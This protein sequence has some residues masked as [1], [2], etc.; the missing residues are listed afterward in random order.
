MGWLAFCAPFEMAKARMVLEVI[1][2]P[3]EMV[4]LVTSFM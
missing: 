4:M 3:L 2:H 1:E